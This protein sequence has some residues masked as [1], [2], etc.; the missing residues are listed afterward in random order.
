MLAG[1]Y[2]DLRAARQYITPTHVATPRHAHIEPRQ[3]ERGQ[4][5]QSIDHV[6]LWQCLIIRELEI[7]C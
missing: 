6:V 7:R 2:G 5:A 4:Y 1:V 3:I